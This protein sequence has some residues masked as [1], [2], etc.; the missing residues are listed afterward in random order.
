[1]VVIWLRTTYTDV[2]ISKQKR[3]NVTRNLPRV[4]DTTIS[5][6]VGKSSS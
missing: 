2:D 6:T 5:T 4:K 1:V 3:I